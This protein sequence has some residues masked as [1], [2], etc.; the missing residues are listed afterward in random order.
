MNV[1]IFESNLINKIERKKNPIVKSMSNIIQRDFFNSFELEKIP[2]NLYQLN[3]D[4][5]SRIIFKKKRKK[6]MYWSTQMNEFLENAIINSDLDYKAI[7]V[8]FISFNERLHV[9]FWQIIK[10]IKLLKSKKHYTINKT[11]CKENVSIDQHDWNEENKN[12]KYENTKRPYV[13]DKDFDIYI[14]DPIIHNHEYDN[15]QSK[16]N[17]FYEKFPDC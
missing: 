10:H 3:N 6:R 1:K 11:K 14:K 13:H 7:A 12:K 8:K 16:M 9:T 4:I 5:N 15:V 2:L 17:V